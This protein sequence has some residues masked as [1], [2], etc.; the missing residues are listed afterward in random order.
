MQLVRGLRGL[1]LIGADIVCYCP[2]Y[3]TPAQI[4]GITASCLLLHFVTL[5]AE[6]LKGRG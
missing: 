1:N 3:D 2:L 4:T 6:R 5:I